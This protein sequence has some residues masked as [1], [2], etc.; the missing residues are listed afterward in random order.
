MILLDTNV[1]SEATKRL[2]Q[3]SVV[4]WIDAQEALSLFICSPVLAELY[5]GIERLAA[6]GRYERLK[7]WIERLE[8]DLYAGR[9]LPFDAAAARAFGRLTAARERTGRRIEPVDALIAAIA[10]ANQMALA[11]R[12]VDDFSGLGL[13]LINPFADAA[14]PPVSPR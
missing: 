8:F 9:V 10:L 2:P 13:D 12:D 1:I 7:V 3:P 11:T 6:G 4:A 14:S 5:Y